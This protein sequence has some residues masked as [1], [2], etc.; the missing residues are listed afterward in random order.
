MEMRQNQYGLNPISKERENDLNKS[1]SSYRDFKLVAR[2][3]DFSIN[4]ADLT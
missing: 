2:P 3:N 1:Q 4:Q